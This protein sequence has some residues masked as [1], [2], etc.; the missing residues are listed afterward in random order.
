MPLLDND[1]VQ[2][3]MIEVTLIK[4]ER[5]ESTLSNF[6]PLS[7][8]LTGTPGVNFNTAGHPKTTSGS[9]IVFDDQPMSMW[10]TSPDPRSMSNA[11]STDSLVGTLGAHSPVP[12]GNLT[13]TLWDS[14]RLYHPPHFSARYLSESQAPPPVVKDSLVIEDFP[15][16]HI[17]TCWMNMV[18]Q[19]LSEWIRVPV[20][21][22]RG[23]EPG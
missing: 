14:A 7:S 20:I 17:S 4:H 9:V 12:P 5:T 6:F 1:D 3:I 23:K 13:T 15:V 2:L 16:G 10:I 8:D 11:T 19:G 21:I 18:K 22:A